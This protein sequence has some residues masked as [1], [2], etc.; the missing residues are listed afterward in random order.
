MTRLS[1]SQ[2]ARFLATLSVCSHPEQAKFWPELEVVVSINDPLWHFLW[3]PITNGPLA[4]FDQ[5]Q[6]CHYFQRVTSHFAVTN[7]PFTL[8]ACFPPI[9]VVLSINNLFWLL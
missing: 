9:S 5:S 4:I 3:P 6:T 7:G 2:R 1:S 8:F